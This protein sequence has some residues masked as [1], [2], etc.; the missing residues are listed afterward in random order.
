MLYASIF[1]HRALEKFTLRSDFFFNQGNG[2]LTL[3]KEDD[4]VYKVKI[5]LT[6][7]RNNP[8]ER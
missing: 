7:G 4:A 1:F 8:L 5:D 6:R 2:N 3:K